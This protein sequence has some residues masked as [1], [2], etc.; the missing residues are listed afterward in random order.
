MIEFKKPLTLLDSQKIVPT[1]RYPPHVL[2][3]LICATIFRCFIKRPKILARILRT[4]STVKNHSLSRL[5]SRNKHRPQTWLDF[6]GLN[7]CRLVLY[8]LSFLIDT[9]I[10][11]C[12]T[13]LRSAQL[14]QTRALNDKVTKCLNR[15][16][17]WLKVWP[18]MTKNWYWCIPFY[19][20]NLPN[21]LYSNYKSITYSFFIKLGTPSAI[22]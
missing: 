3:Q 22:Y 7:T 11:N 8:T 18:K 13:S 14:H 6:S 19:Q 17:H 20:K 21:R 2:K 16:T 4:S 1:P 15:V 9:S 10:N 5:L 12:I